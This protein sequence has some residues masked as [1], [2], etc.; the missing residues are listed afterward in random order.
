MPDNTFLR[1]VLLQKRAVVFSTSPLFLS[2]CSIILILIPL[3]FP[4]FLVEFQSA[5]IALLLSALVT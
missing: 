4:I 3:F 1:L 5:I 2:L